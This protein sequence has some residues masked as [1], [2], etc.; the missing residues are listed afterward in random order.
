MRLESINTYE[1]LVAHMWLFIHGLVV[2]IGQ[3]LAS[4][5]VR[6]DLYAQLRTRT[7]NIL[8]PYC[9]IF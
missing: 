8:P 1:A 3:T 7:G 9:W 6:Y 5:I 4:A 2:R